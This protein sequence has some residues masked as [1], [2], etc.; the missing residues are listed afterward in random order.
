MVAI[1]VP[2]LE[3]VGPRFIS[4]S[5]PQR[6]IGCAR[7]PS[8]SPDGKR[9]RPGRHRRQF[10]IGNT[11]KIAGWLRPIGINPWEKAMSI[12]SRRKFLQFTAPA[13]ASLIAMPAMVQATPAMLRGIRP[14]GCCLTAGAAA[15]LAKVSTLDPKN[16]VLS[17]GDAETDRHLGAALLRLATTFK[18]NPGFAFYDDRESP[19]AFATPATLVGDGPGTVL[20]G[21]RYFVERMAENDDGMTVIATCAHEFGHIHQFTG[22]YRAELVRLDSTD[23]P[24]ELHADFLAGFFLATR[25]REYSNLNLQK[26]GQQY[27][28]KLGDNAFDSKKHHGT[29]EERLAAVTAGFDLGK[30]TGQDIDQ[31]A[32]AGVAYVRNVCG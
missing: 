7:R 8:L 6:V 17:S 29:S 15:Q 19:N 26:V 5:A 31:V 2:A 12:I 1:L 18:V 16:L 23:K 30:S 24:V 28:E 9:R 14:C 13:T 4:L 3:R 11:V 22:T 27:N 25:K 10:L 20:M 32:A 21:M